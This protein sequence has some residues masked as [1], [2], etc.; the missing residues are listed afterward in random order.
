MD[1]LFVH[2]HLGL[3]DH[4]ICNGLI[5]KLSE[6]YDVKLF[7]KNHNMLNVIQMFLDIKNISLIGINSDLDV[8]K[9][10]SD[11]QCLKLGIALNTNFDKSMAESWDQIFYT[12]AN[13]DFMLS[14]KNFYVPKPFTQ[15]TVP[16]HPYIFMCNKG[17]DGIDR[18]NYDIIRSDLP[19]IYGNTGGFFDNIDLIT[20]AAE[21]HCIDSSYIHLI[22]RLPEDNTALFF[23]KYHIYRTN[24]NYTLK[25]KWTI[26]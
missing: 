19:I 1:K 22:D 7:C 2:H 23:H 11:N 26:I 9:Y 10:I 8:N 12:Q 5:R 15:L 16:S 14:W 4:I 25:K 6:S 21:I 18:I 20:H 24:S 13:I 3:G 17:S